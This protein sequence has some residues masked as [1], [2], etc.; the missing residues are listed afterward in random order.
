M[1]RTVSE[2]RI[3]DYETRYRFRIQDDPSTPGWNAERRLIDFMSALTAMP[4]L[5]NCGYSKPQK[6]VFFHSGECWVAEG[7]ATVSER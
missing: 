1:Q 3:G 4:D 5:L 2:T 7:E 6:L